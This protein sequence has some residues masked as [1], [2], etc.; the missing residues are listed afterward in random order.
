MSSLEEPEHTPV[1]IHHSH[2]LVTSN[3]HTSL[4]NVVGWFSVTVIVLIVLTRLGTRRAKS[5]TVGLDDG[6]IVLSALV[7]IGQTVTVSLGVG[8][9]LGKYT[10][11]ETQVQLEAQQKAI[12][13]FTILF[14]IGQFFA[15]ISIVCFVIALTPD[16][17][18]RYLSFGLGAIS[19]IWM[20]TSVFGFAFQCDAPETWKF[21]GH[22]C[23]DRLKFY[24]F[25]EIFNVC[26]DTMLALFPS[27]IIFGLQLDTKRKVITISF[28]M[29]RI[30]VVGASVT[31]LVVI[32]SRTDD[33]FL[34]WTFALLVTIIQTFGI[35]TACG[36]YLKPFLD[37]INSG[38]IG[39]D[40]L[41][42]RAGGTVQ[43]YNGNSKD[44]KN[45]KQSKTSKKSGRSIFSHRK[46]DSS[47]VDENELG[48]VETGQLGPM[49]G[50]RTQVETV[51]KGDEWEIGSQSSRAKIIRQTTTYRV[52]SETSE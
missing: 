38:M 17:T 40:D 8:N 16:R 15:K 47:H 49:Q 21:I 20:L 52:S 19:G 7:A 30:L 41:R 51:Q 2:P 46:K 32:Y 6:S 31:Q 18:H 10:G 34:S 29:S 1:P 12:Y 11:E 44:S 22:Q 39:N 45:S 9:G 43:D 42:R 5:R 3:D 13:A 26:L 36:P 37:S 48:I 24:T 27:F 23:I 33:P 25:V 35:V 4:L 50:H 28:F 14:V